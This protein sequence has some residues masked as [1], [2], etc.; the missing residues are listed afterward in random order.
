MNPALFTSKNVIVQGITGTHGTFHTKAMIDAGT[1]IVGGTSPS[2]TGQTVHGVPV[3]DSIASIKKIFE[4]DISIIFVPA[5]FAAGAIFEAIDNHVP[6]IICITE[7]IPTHDMLRIKQR[8]M[9]G[10]STLIGPN[11]PGVLLPGGNTLGIIPTRFGTIGN[12]GVVSRSGTLTYETVAGLT[13]KGIGQKYVIGIGGDPIKGAD[14]VDILTLFENDSDVTGI[15]M[16][17]EIGGQSE[18]EAAKFIRQHVTKPI[19]GYIAGWQAPLDTRLGHSGA[20][21]KSDEESAETKTRLLSEAGVKMAR[22]VVEL[23]RLI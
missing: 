9:K 5:K 15:V 12:I 11:C 2:K 14:F 18:I 19:F 10:N 17:G 23:V 6:L 1:T 13:Q 8:L 3:F 20:I 22:N 21:L 7:G 16:V 4:V